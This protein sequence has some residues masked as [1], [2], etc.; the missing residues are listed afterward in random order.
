MAGRTLRRQVYTLHGLLLQCPCL[1]SAAVR[2]AALA[3]LS[4][5]APVYRLWLLLHLLP[6]VS[7][8]HCAALRADA[9][10]CLL[11]V[12]LSACTCGCHYPLVR[13][14]AGPADHSTIKGA[15]AV[16][17]TDSAPRCCQRG[18]ADGQ[19]TSCVAELLP[20]FSGNLPIAVALL[21]Q[22]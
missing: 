13:L 18:G 12:P 4:G 17:S 2:P 11:Q 22:R 5:L 3:C 21:A 19:C 6:L 14:E 1:H 10:L 7:P 16:W 8:A 20:G 9:L 15:S